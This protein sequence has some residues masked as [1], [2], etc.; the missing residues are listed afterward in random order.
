MGLYVCVRAWAK[1]CGCL[2]VVCAG[3]E[4]CVCVRACVRVRVSGCEVKVGVD[5]VPLRFA[6]LIEVQ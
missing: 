4:V 5:G 1:V 2:G 6:C 3:V